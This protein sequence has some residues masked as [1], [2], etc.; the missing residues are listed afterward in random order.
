MPHAKNAKDAKKE[1]ILRACIPAI[2]LKSYFQRIIECVKAKFLCLK[3]K[4]FPVVEEE[5]SPASDLAL[6]DLS[7]L[8]N[9]IF[10]S[11]EEILKS[12]KSLEEQFSN[13][14]IRKRWSH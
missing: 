11:Y 7:A 4:M 13:I 6:E 2:E 10:E 8:L 5:S 12:N 9:E 1:E 3:R 14:V